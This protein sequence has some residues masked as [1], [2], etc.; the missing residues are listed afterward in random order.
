MKKLGLLNAQLSRTIATLGHGQAITICD[1]GLPID[2]QV[3]RVDL[4]LI[5]G[6]PT[7]MQ[8]L[9]AVL[10]EQNVEEVIL[11]SEFE[12]ISPE[13]HV[14]VMTCIARLE[15]E[16]GR[17]VNVVTVPHCEFKSISNQSVAVVRTGECTP[18]A[19]IILRS[20][21]CF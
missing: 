17:P 11:A 20:G 14:E 4:A 7:F 12:Q 16:Q 9:E 2:Q 3:E 19:N 1:C 5:P 8:T 15:A 18:Y 10:S 21:V 6:V 13:L